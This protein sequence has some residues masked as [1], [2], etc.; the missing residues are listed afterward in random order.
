MTKFCQTMKI[1]KKMNHR[2]LRKFSKPLMVIGLLGL[3]LGSI[4]TYLVEVNYIAAKGFQV[5]DLEKEITLLEEENE[6]LQVQVVQLKSMTDLSE[7]VQELGMVPVDK[8][9]YFET[10]GQVVA[11]R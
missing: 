4:I 6:K 10:T 8:I 7:K 11:R 2:K 5:R 9:T 1:G 3:I